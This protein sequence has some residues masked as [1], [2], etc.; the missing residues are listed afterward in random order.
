MKRLLAA[1]AALA[2]LLMGC[3]S[4][5]V[6]G[7]LLVTADRLFDGRRLVEGGAVLIGGSKVVAVGSDLD[8]EAKRR[9]DLGD[10]TL[11]PGFI[12]LHVH[13]AGE[14]GSLIGGVTTVRDLGIPIGAMQPPRA[15]PG[16]LRILH[17]GPLLTAPGGY[18]IPVFGRPLGLPFRGADGARKAVEL[19]AE[20]GAVIVKLA[21]EPGFASP[22]PMPSEQEA[23]AVVHEAHSR[24]L[25]VT[26][27]V[28]EGRGTRLALDAGVDELA[29]MPCYDTDAELIRELAR[30]DVPIV[31]TLHVLQGCP[32]RDSN[33]RR[34]VEAGGSL[35]YGS[36][37]GNPTIPPGIDI[38]E[39]KLMVTAGLTTAEAI[40]AATADAGKLLG[41]EPLG[42]LVE[43][44]P[45]DVI[46]VRGDPLAD[47]DALDDIELVVAGGRPVVAEGKLNLPGP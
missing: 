40:T 34:F 39:L 17:A 35:L 44:A 8:A 21:L 36:D 20:N 26:A 25:E 23:A 12:D 38:D 16:S 18:P 41:L 9:I 1:L 27:H 47:L 30:K 28:T 24:G 45:A 42:T 14:N 37:Y 33:A 46:G 22:L 10:A 5:P 32:D 6:R 3:G 15:S 7:D 11:L 29:H 13:G 19:V 31:G 2:A 4:D 43:G